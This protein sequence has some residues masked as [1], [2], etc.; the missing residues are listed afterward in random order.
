MSTTKLRNKKDFETGPFL[1]QS[2]SFKTCKTYITAISGIYCC[3]KIVQKQNSMMFISKATTDAADKHKFYSNCSTAEVS[4]RNFCGG[5]EMK[6]TSSISGIEQ[7]RASDTAAKSV[8]P[9]F[10]FRLVITSA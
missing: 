7:A 2:W 8:N 10:Y 1:S 6:L 3:F 9:C 4:E 5:L